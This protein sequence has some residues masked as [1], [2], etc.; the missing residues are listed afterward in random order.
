MQ[1]FEIAGIIRRPPVPR[2]GSVEIRILHADA[3]IPRLLQQDLP[4]QILVQQPAAHQIGRIARRGGEQHGLEVAQQD[5]PLAHLGDGCG[6]AMI[7]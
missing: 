5:L 6:T 4:L 3:A 7:A 1:L 2:H